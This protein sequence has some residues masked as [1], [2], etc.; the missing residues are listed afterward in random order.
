M[1]DGQYTIGTDVPAGTYTA[2]A[3]PAA[4][5]W[6]IQH[7]VGLVG[8]LLGGGQSSGGGAGDHTVNLQHGDKFTTA[9]CGTWWR[10]T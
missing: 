9:H 7:P 1:G 4:C 6:T 10:Q 5:S 2:H 8:G 3:A